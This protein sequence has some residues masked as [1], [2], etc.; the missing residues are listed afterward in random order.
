[1]V[2]L[3]KFHFKISVPVYL[4]EV[5]NKKKTKKPNRFLLIF[6]AAACL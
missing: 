4:M 2:L 5:Y 1:M 6:Q 3:V